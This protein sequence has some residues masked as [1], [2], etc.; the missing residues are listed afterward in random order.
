MV[1]EPPTTGV[2]TQIKNQLTANQMLLSS[3]FD[4]QLTESIVS[5]DSDKQK[6]ELYDL[7][8]FVQPGFIREKTVQIGSYFGIYSGKKL[9]AASGERI[10]MNSFTEVSAVVTLPDF[11]K[12]G[13]AQQFLKKATDTIFSE[14]KT[15]IIQVDKNNVHEINPIE[16][17][18]FVTRE[19]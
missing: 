2:Q 14:N 19:K 6:K 3:P 1:G 11:Q 10:K 15:P 13:Y 17:L 4:L 16:R 9:I 8:N 12:S 7:V 5:L 18:G